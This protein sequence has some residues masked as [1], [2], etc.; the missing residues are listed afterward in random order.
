VDGIGSDS[1]AADS[2]HVVGVGG[3][4]EHGDRI[5]CGEVE[6]PCLDGSGS[7][8]S[9]SWCLTTSASLFHEEQ[10]VCIQIGTGDAYL[11]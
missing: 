8:P 10:D 6:R 11:Y 4:L 5:V 9:A 3:I 2:G 7:Q 1:S